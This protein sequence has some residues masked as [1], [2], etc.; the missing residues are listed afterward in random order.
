[1]IPKKCIECDLMFEGECR[2]NSDITGE[3]ARLDY[4]KCKIEGI[5]E[6]VSIEIDSSGYETFVPEKCEQC[7]H[8]KMDKYRG[9]ICSFEKDIWG[10]FPRSLDWGSW[11]PNFPIIGLGANLK[12][13]KY[14]IILIKNKK[15]AEAVKE[16]KRL[17][18][19]IGFKKAVESVSLLK[20]KIDKYY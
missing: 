17:N 10:D 11:Q 8:L 6:P 12:L 4:G 2:R 19:G 9:Y 15:T 3:Y 13:T 5:T 16:I 20:N 14:L 7:D 1:M 18:E